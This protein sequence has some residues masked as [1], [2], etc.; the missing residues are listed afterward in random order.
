MTRTNKKGKRLFFMVLPF[1]ILVFLLSYMPLYGWIY[2]FFD[3]KPGFSLARTNFV[4]FANFR[5]IIQDSYAMED[6]LRVMKNTFAMSLLG[7]LTSWIPMFFAIFLNEIKIV[8][9]RRTV[10][11]LTTIPNFI[12]WVL[13]Y[14]VAYA[15]FA[16]DDGFVNRVLFNAGFIEDKIRFLANSNHVWLSMLAWGIWKGLGW[17]SIMYI[18]ALNS[19]DQEQ[20][21]A[22]KVDGGGR[23]VCIWYI[24]IPGLLPTYFVL[25]I[26]SI[27]NFINNGMEQYFVFQNVM[28]KANIEVLDLYVYN[29]GIAGVNYSYSIA[30]GILKSVVSLV[31]LFFANGCSRL[32]RKEPV[33]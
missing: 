10:Q 28:N 26:L 3:W 17:N 33:F 7:I 9:Y 16:V 15:M 22:A 19:I 31:L 29:Q 8:P 21:E 30:V 6:I 32:F 25:F 23:F 18:A 12:S 1:M 5:N 27:A 14:S 13:V 4:G 24:T 20:Y 2:A 11:T